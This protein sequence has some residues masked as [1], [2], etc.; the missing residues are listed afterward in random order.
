ML[1]SSA[2]TF[3]FQL[4]NNLFK[5]SHLLCYLSNGDVSQQAQNT[6]HKSIQKAIENSS[7]LASLVQYNEKGT[8]LIHP[9]N[10][11]DLLVLLVEHG[12]GAAYGLAKDLID[13]N[14]DVSLSTLLDGVCTP[15]VGPGT[16][17]KMEAP[18]PVIVDTLEPIGLK[19]AATINIKANKDMMDQ[20]TKKYFELELAEIDARIKTLSADVLTPVKPIDVPATVIPGVV[21][22][23]SQSVDQVIGGGTPKR[24]HSIVAYEFERRN[25]QEAPQKYEQ[26]DWPWIKKYYTAFTLLGSPLLKDWIIQMANARNGTTETVKL[27]MNMEEMTPAQFKVFLSK[28][29]LSKSPR[30]SI[31]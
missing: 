7:A 10:W 27:P 4:P 24:F 30:L 18:T 26:K 2:K 20:L 25:G 23:Q 13:K 12:T 19:A 28:S 29:L 16:S 31:K 3:T 5:L 1:K 15:V 11:D 22:P 9:D 6:M 17:T 21:I 8:I 14:D